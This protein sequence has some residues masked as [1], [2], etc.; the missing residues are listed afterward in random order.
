[1]TSVYRVSLR[2]GILIL[3]GIFNEIPKFA[4]NK[5]VGEPG[6]AAPVIEIKGQK[7][8]IGLPGFVGLPG[9]VGQKG[10]RGDNGYDGQKGESGTRGMCRFIKID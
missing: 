2:Y 10:E 3:N 7:G 9:A 8:E 5:N 4:L 1:M 6:L